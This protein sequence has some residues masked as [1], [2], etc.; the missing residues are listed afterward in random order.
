M[1]LFALQVAGEGIFGISV[2]VFQKFVYLITA[3]SKFPEML[4]MV[5][6]IIIT[7][8]MMQFYFGRYSDEQLG[9]NTAV[10]NSIV[11]IFI[12]IDL[13][14][15]LFN[16]GGIHLSVLTI[17]TAVACIVA[18]EGIV[19]L[20][21]NFFH[22]WPQRLAFFLSA[23]PVNISAYIAIVMVYSDILEPV[24]SET[25]MVA[26]ISATCLFIVLLLLFTLVKKILH[27][28]I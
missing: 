19:M 5:V 13:F 21:L 6:P 24:S 28:E 27:R 16:N 9:W 14:R 22:L 12:A 18:F 20:L 7:T 23:L 3:P 10:G 26:S 25:I 17:K 15:Y 11:L 2:S 4:W 8:V 1:A